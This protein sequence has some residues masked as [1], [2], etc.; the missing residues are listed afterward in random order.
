MQG[1]L[2]PAVSRFLAPSRFLGEFM[3]RWGLPEQSVRVITTG[4]DPQRYAPRESTPGD[5]RDGRPL[6]VLFLG[7]Y[8]VH[9]GAHVLLEAWGKLPAELRAKARLELYGPPFRSDAAYL[10]RLASLAQA[11]GAHLGEALGREAI[12]PRLRST[13]LL[14]VP[15][16][17]FE[18]APLVILEAL[19]VRTPLCVSGL[20]GMA[21]L[22]RPGVSGWHFQAGDAG[23][24]AETLARVLREPEALGR[25]YRHEER[26]RTF[27]HTLDDIEAI[28]AE[29]CTEAAR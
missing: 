25:L 21:E 23:D 16:I 2:A 8:A 14:V 28:Y 20:G 13:D 5:V 18:N 26:V 12:A 22:V 27:E 7:T 29:V 24:L 11:C 3:V 15:S 10:E 19:A 17:W 9:K 4:I 6:R 1:T